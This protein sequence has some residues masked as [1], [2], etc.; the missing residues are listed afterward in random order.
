MI[1]NYEVFRVGETPI[2]KL[3]EAAESLPVFSENRILVCE[4]THRFKETDWKY[5]EPLLKEKATHCVVIF[6]SEAPDK[7]KKIIK[8]LS[9]KCEVISA[10]KA[11]DSEL[12][13]WIQWMAE[14]QG[15]S[16]SNSA[17]QLLKEHTGHDLTSVENE[18]KKI[19]NFSGSKTKISVED[20]LHIVP[21]TRPENIFALS[22]AIGKKKSF[23]GLVLPGSF[24][25]RQSKCHWCFS[26]N[27]TAYTNFG[28]SKGRLKERL[29]FTNHQCQDRCTAFLY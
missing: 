20:I 17:V 11:K 29:Y 2:E 24:I 7:R 5:I 18:I 15:L 16:F 23:I 25:G 8:Q 6:I 13:A 10:Q 21:R 1:F 9:Q 3:Q 12:P 26:F 22:Q 4:E 19:K 28:T 27:H 14:Q